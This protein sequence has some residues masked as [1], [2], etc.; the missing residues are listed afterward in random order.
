LGK[1]EHD[2]YLSQSE[3]GS[4][5]VHLCIFDTRLQ[6]EQEQLGQQRR[7]PGIP[8]LAAANEAAAFYV[9]PRA[10]VTTLT[11]LRASVAAE[12]ARAT[13][14]AST[15][16]SFQ[17]ATTSAFGFVIESSLSGKL[18]T[19]PPIVASVFDGGQASQAGIRPGWTVYAVNGARVANS[20]ELLRRLSE[21]KEAAATVR[22]RPHSMVRWK[23][24]SPCRPCPHRRAANPTPWNST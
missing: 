19:Q 8:N 15:V 18:A 23:Y 10:A 13:T 20:N 21:A 11:A 2:R 3:C 7:A 6:S 9:Q 24:P 22:K 14:A 12:L 17:L 1:Y 5:G 4:S 16:V